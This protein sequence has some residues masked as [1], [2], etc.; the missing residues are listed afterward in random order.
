[1]GSARS[2][3]STTT[4]ANPRRRLRAAAR[5]G[6]MRGYTGPPVGLPGAGDGRD[7]AAGL[8]HDPLDRE[9]TLAVDLTLIKAL[10]LV[11]PRG[12]G[13]GASERGAPRLVGALGGKPREQPPEA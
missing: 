8:G 2:R 7:A 9:G 3:A 4:W 11:G 5:L 1:A 10:R 13:L 12:G 6:R